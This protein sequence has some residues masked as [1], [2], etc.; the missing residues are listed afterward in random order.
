MRVENCHASESLLA[1]SHSVHLA[2]YIPT[3]LGGM[4]ILIKFT[5]AKGLIGVSSNPSGG[6]RK[7]V[8]SAIFKTWTPT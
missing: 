8:R 1:R 6:E 4:M 5:G 7:V 3:S 2:E